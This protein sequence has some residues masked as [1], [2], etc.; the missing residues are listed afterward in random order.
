MWYQ[1][2]NKNK[3]VYCTKCRTRYDMSWMKSPKCGQC[4]F[5]GKK[6]V[7]KVPGLT[8]EEQFGALERG[9]MK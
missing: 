6:K 2:D 8:D 1:V 7:M 9:G 4:K 5:D 3:Q